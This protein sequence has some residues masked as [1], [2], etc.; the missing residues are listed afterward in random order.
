MN[1]PLIIDIKHF[2]EAGVKNSLITEFLTLYAAEMLTLPDKFEA[3]LLAEDYLGAEQLLHSFKGASE[4]VGAYR[5]SILM[6][7]LE[8][9]IKADHQQ[10]DPVQMVEEFRQGVE[11]TLVGVKKKIA[12]LS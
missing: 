7:K 9:S 3:L 10:L 8:K 12:C 2:H 1:K 5:V 11:Q 6:Q 4:V